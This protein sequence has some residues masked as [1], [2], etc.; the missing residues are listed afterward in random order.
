MSVKVGIFQL[1]HAQGLPLPSYAT[2]YAPCFFLL[3]STVLAGKLLKAHA[4]SRFN[5]II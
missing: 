3:T 4:Q 1:A 5:L 2:A